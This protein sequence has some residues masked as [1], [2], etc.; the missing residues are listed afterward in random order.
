MQ[1]FPGGYQ[2][3]GSFCIPLLTY[4]PWFWFYFPTGRLL[5]LYLFPI[6]YIGDLASRNWGH[7]FV[8]NER[9]SKTGDRMAMKAGFW[10]GRGHTVSHVSLSSCKVWNRDKLE[11]PFL[12]SFS[13]ALKSCSHSL[14]FLESWG[15]WHEKCLSV[16][17]IFFLSYQPPT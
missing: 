5:L 9:R 11:S 10:S 16:A 1:T 6:N 2:S 8:V 17:S 14:G 12:S 13:K 4:Q 3:L 15:W 7:C